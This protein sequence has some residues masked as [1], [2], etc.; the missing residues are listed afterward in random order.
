MWGGGD[1]YEKFMGRWSRLVAAEFLD[2]LAIA[3]Q[4]RW[5]D[6]GC[7]T[8]VLTETILR[9]A[10][11]QRVYG[12]D[13]FEA[14]IKQAQFQV[15]DERVE[16]IVSDVDSVD[17]PPNTFDAI[18]S[19]LAL[20]FIPDINSALQAMH[21]LSKPHGIVA[22]Y[23]WDYSGKMEFLR[24]FWDA[25]I[26]LDSSATTLDEG[27]LFPICNPIALKNAFS[28]NDFQSIE[29]IPLD[30]PTVFQDFDDYWLP[31]LGGRGP[32]GAYLATLETAKLDELRELLR[33]TLPVT[34]DGTIPLV[35]RAWAIRAQKID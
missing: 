13:P 19:G 33:Q 8:G 14:Q 3:P 7:G 35:A 5:L 28:A 30:V 26:Q 29:V 20:N 32:A 10:S 4:A 9:T 34:T 27:Q 23:V 12:I 16:F 2:W 17:L 22:A 21:K 24:Y 6:V 18:V 1:V 25:V 11:T 31:F 15:M